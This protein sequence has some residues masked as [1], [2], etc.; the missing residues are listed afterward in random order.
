[1]TQSAQISQKQDGR[2]YISEHDTIEKLGASLFSK[3]KENY[4]KST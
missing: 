3:A 2:I 4:S 1:M